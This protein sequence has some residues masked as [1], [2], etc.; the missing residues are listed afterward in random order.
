MTHSKVSLSTASIA[1]I[2]ASHTRVD[3]S[4]SAVVNVATGSSSAMPR[5]SRQ[6]H[7]GDVAVQPDAVAFLYRDVTG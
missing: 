6:R 2:Q 1:S 5:D 3:S 7:A 4:L